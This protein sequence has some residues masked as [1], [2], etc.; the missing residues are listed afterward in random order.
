MLFV[1]ACGMREQ[2]PQKRLGHASPESV[3]V[4]TRVSDEAVLTEYAKRLGEGDEVRNAGETE[5]SRP[6]EVGRG[7]RTVLRLQCPH[8]RAPGVRGGCVR[9]AGSAHSGLCRERV[10]HEIIIWRSVACVV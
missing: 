3:K 9:R 10:Y 6:P 4:Y 7:N 5:R 8:G 2:P 1:G